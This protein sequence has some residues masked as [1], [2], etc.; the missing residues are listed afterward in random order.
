MPDQLLDE[1][2]RKLD[3][4]VD[5]N[6]KLNLREARDVEQGPL[7]LSPADQLKF[8]KAFVKFPKVTASASANAADPGDK[9]C[10]PVVLDIGQ[11]DSDNLLNMA[12]MHCC[13]L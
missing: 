3:I 4:F 1:V 12:A 11:S 7:Q 13:H 9:A 8:G 2:D 10:V 5:R 6:H